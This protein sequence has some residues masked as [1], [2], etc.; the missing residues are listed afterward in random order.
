MDLINR[1]W[2]HLEEQPFVTQT[3]LNGPMPPVVSGHDYVYWIRETFERF[4]GFSLH[5]STNITAL[6]CEGYP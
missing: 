2:I 4:G 6:E 3:C 5:E 1:E